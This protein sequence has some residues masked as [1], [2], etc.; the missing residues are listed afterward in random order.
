[1][2]V[3]G[4]HD[5]RGRPGRA[6]GQGQV[7]HGPDTL[8]GALCGIQGT[9]GA[10][11]SCCVGLALSDDAIGFIQGVGAVDLSDV[12]HLAAQKGLALVARHMEPGHV[13][14]VVAA[15]EVIDGGIHQS[16]PAA[17]AAFIMMAHSMRLRNSS[18]PAS[19]TPRMEP[20]AWKALAAQPPEQYSLAQQSAHSGRA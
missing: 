8:A 3:P 10:K 18:Q 4:G 2:D 12:Q 16:S 1:M 14:V 11:Q 13:R 9:V 20:V 5:D 15:Q 19:Y 7:Q 17:S 6:A